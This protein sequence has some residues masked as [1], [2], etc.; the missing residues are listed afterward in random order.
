ML[1]DGA[2]RAILAASVH[3]ATDDTGFGL[4]GHAYEVALRQ[5]YR[6]TFSRR[7]SRHG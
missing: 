6:C 7:P 5:R 1:N 2:A 4:L 3:A